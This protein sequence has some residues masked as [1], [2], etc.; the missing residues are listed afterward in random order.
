MVV[1]EMYVCVCVCAW[2]A[3]SGRLEYGICVAGV[4]WGQTKG[5]RG[6]GQQRISRGTEDHA[7]PDGASLGG[8]HG[9][10]VGY[11]ITKGTGG[12]YAVLSDLP[13]CLPACT[14]L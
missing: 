8:G 5:W 11:F 3:R 7:T 9:Q 4:G 10:R 1:C 2:R 12:Q 14:R 13:A 6:G